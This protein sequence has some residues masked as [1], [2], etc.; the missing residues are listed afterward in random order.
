MLIPSN[1]WEGDTLKYE[2]PWLTPESICVLEKLITPETSIVEFGCGGSTIFFATRCRQLVT[3]DNNRNW[4]FKT[5]EIVKSKNLINVTMHA[6]N[7]LDECKT[8]FNSYFQAVD[9]AL[10]DCC[11]ISRY[12]LTK[13]MVDK[14]RIIVVDNYSADYVGDTD[15]L[16]GPEWTI[17]KY[18]DLHWAGSGTKIYRKK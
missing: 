6:V 4:L 8:V 1:Y 12:E 9:I 3:M 18:D 2:Y 15:K 13:F 14:A 17:D 7:S 5:H 11:D 10:V 16:F